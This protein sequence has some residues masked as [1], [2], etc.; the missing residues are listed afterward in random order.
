[1]FFDKDFLGNEFRKGTFKSGHQPG[2][3][4]GNANTATGAVTERSTVVITILLVIMFG[5]QTDLMGI[6]TIGTAIHCIAAGYE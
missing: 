2:I 5:G 4:K 3:G 1:M 6:C